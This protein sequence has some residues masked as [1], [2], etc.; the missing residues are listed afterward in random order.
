M[1]LSD[2][3]WKAFTTDELFSIKSGTT[4]DFSKL[5]LK[6]DSKLPCIGAK[7][8]NNGV[9][10]FANNEE[11]KVEGNALVFIKTG[12]GSVGLTLYKAED[13]I[14]HKNV[15]IGYNVSL[16]KYIG[17]FIATMYNKQ[18]F[19]YNYGYGLNQLRVKKT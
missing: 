18:K 9:V 3:E 11:L 14:P 2:R 7:Y 1:K 5:N 6:N 12:E 8:K 19:I 4:S 15:Y 16:N 17:L 13:F 10:G